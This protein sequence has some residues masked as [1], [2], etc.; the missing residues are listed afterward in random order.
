MARSKISVRTRIKCAGWWWKKFR[1]HSGKNSL[2]NYFQNRNRLFDRTKAMASRYAVG[3][4]DDDD[5]VDVLKCPVH[6]K[7]C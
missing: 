4:L 2:E 6:N 5:D 1:V 3:T 7:H